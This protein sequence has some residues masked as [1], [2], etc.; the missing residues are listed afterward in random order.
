MAKNI[1]EKRPFNNRYSDVF[2]HNF[3]LQMGERAG[4][5]HTILWLA[6]QAATAVLE[7]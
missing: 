6:G 7:P 1:G 5:K 2:R 3:A 4:L